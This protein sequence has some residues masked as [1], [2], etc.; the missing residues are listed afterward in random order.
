MGETRDKYI[1]YENAAYQFLGR[2][3]TGLSS[4]HNFFSISPLF[5]N[6]PDQ[7]LGAGDNLLRKP[8]CRSIK[9]E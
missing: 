1:K 9:Q 3:L 6:L 8:C 7:E 4:L 5:F 2:T